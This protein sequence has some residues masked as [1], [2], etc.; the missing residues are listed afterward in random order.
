MALVRDQQP[1]LLAEAGVLADCMF[2][3]RAGEKF[4]LFRKPENV[5]VKPPGREIPSM[6]KP[7]QPPREVK[8]GQ[9]YSKVT[10]T[11]TETGL[12]KKPLV[13]IT[14]FKCGKI[15][16]KANSCSEILPKPNPA[17]RK[18]P[19]VAP[20]VRVRDL[21]S[22]GAA[23]PEL[24]SWS[25]ADENEGAESDFVF[26]APNSQDRPETPRGP[27]LK[28][29]SVSVVQNIPGG[30]EGGVK[31]S[32]FLGRNSPKPLSPEC[33][34]WVQTQF[35]EPIYV[36]CVQVMGRVDLG[37][38]ITSIAKHLV[39]PEQY[40]PDLQ[41]T[42]TAY[43][44][45]T[46]QARVAELVLSY[47]NW[48]GRHRV[49][50][51]STNSLW[52]VLIGAD[53]LFLHHKETER[54]AERDALARSQVLLDALKYNGK[55]AKASKERAVGLPEPQERS[56]LLQP[57]GGGLMEC[58]VP[59][60][61][62]QETKTVLLKKGS[63]QSCKSKTEANPAALLKAEKP[64]SLNEHLIMACTKVC[65]LAED[66][67]D[68]VTESQREGG[69]TE[70]TLPKGLTHEQQ[71]QLFQILTEFKPMFSS[72]PGRTDLAIHSINIGNHS[73]MQASPYRVTGRNAEVVERE[74]QAMLEM[75]VI[76][77]STSPWSSPIVLVAKR[78]ANE[79]RFCVDYRKLNQISQVD[80]YPLPRMDH[81]IE[82]LGA[83]K[84]ITTLDLTKG[85][86]Q[87]P[88]DGD[89]AVKSAFVT[90]MGLFQFKV[91][92]FGLRNAPA[93]FMRLI[94]SVINGLGEFSCAYLDDIAIFSPD[95]NSHL[96][97]LRIVLQRLQAAGLT[98]KAQ[99]CQF[100][101]GEVVYLGH[102]VGQDRVKPLE[103]KIEAMH[104]WPVPKT[105]KQVQSF[106]GLAG[107]YR[108]FAPHFSSVATPLTEL[109]KKT[110]PMRVIWT[111]KCQS[112][113]DA[114]K[115]MLV[116][117]PVLKAPDFSSPFVV[118]TDA[119]NF[120]L[121]AAL[122]QKDAAGDLHPIAYISKKLI[123]RERNLATIEKECLA[124]VWALDMLRPYLWGR[125]FQLQ[126]DHSPL[127]WLN[128]MKNSNQNL[129]RWSLALQD[130]DF[131]IQFIKGRDNV[132]ADALSRLSV[133]VD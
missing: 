15:G 71:N 45:K 74:V 60:A 125:H 43:G 52:D 106:L 12:Q 84:Y 69:I 98:I 22:P 133:P 44:P 70:V 93:T 109:C 65:E 96:N 29:L 50:V 107:Y 39:K 66:S 2:K 36:N 102:R 127:C 132:V 72:K 78:E 53:L 16:H 100:G 30:R 97:H 64:N 48:T 103:A 63:L 111:D 46:V 17:G 38:E 124:L 24:S 126:T 108:K 28:A 41:V 76:E 112:A 11:L 94:N 95:W 49:L 9:S 18:N 123:P 4:T 120:G 20:V 23:P 40:V 79:V 3:N 115:T 21:A 10:S 105:K 26:S 86:W 110:M 32:L 92:P 5:P 59:P 121:G 104:N 25:S 85:Y 61:G 118:Q 130:F 75:G 55:E 42:V 117:Y 77:P 90:H 13:E 88:L 1:R 27:V 14:C 114:L 68:L 62:S 89:A 56:S 8:G 57:R 119:S 101:L 33:K 37:A 67:L 82:R 19:R 80:P 113:F 73:P 51:H 31:N 35:S 131:S 128:R 129:L 34:E 122:L 87:V 91:L 58:K 6:Q 54:R 7:W 83:A 47:K 81:L 99:K 116:N